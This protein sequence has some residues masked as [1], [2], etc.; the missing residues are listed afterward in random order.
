MQSYINILLSLNRI[1][2]LEKGFSR[3]KKR[4]HG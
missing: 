1:E 2:A 3:Q 4:R